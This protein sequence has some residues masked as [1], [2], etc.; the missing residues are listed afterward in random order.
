MKKES[1]TTVPFFDIHEV[2]QENDTLVAMRMFFGA[3][4]LNG[5]TNGHFLQV[6]QLHFDH[7]NT[8]TYDH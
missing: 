1:S 7:K 2:D 4:L 5:L 6:P 3:K 8:S